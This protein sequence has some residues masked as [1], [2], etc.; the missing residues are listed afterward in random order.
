MLLWNQKNAFNEVKLS[1]KRRW[2]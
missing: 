2:Q 1:S